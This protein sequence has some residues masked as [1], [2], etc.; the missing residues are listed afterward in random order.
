M[1][2]NDVVRT[3]LIGVGMA[4]ILL[5]I[6]VIIIVRPLASEVANIVLDNGL[7]FGGII[8]FFVGLTYRDE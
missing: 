4:M 6:I 7:I 1:N 8:T 3:I 2:D 5:H